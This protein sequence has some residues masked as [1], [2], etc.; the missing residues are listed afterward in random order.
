MAGS[1]LSNLK[2]R[3]GG[4]RVAGDA[5]PATHRSLLHLGPEPQALLAC[6]RRSGMERRQALVSGPIQR[7][8][9]ARPSGLSRGT[10]AMRSASTV[11][12]ARVRMREDGSR[13]SPAWTRP[14]ASH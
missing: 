5:H 11:M 14:W 2:A 1:C 6:L 13:I 3:A 9:L 7:S 8:L 12:A 10:L 4:P